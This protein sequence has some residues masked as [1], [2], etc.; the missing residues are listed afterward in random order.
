MLGIVT[1]MDGDGNREL[2]FADVVLNEATHE[3]TRAGVQVDLTPTEFN[4]LRFFLLNPRRVLSKPQILDCVWDADFGGDPRIVETYVS[5]LRRKLDPLGPPLIHTVRMV[6]YALRETRSVAVSSAA[7]DA[8]ALERK[9]G[10]PPALL[11][12]GEVENV[13]VAQRNEPLGNLD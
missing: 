7:S 9:P 13:P 8:A 6:G 1:L 11:A 12:A 4:L 10:F 2:R 3:V 5:Y